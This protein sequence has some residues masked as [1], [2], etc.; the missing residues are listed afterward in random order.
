MTNQSSLFLVLKVFGM[1]EVAFPDPLKHFLK[2]ARAQ[3]KGD[4]TR[5]GNSVLCL[6]AV[7][8]HRPHPSF[9]CGLLQA[10]T[11]SPTPNP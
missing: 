9:T 6:V 7:L 11:I 3:A 10:L 1:F 4:G 8:Y 2:T 5:A